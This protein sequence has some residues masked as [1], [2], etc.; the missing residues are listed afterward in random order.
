ML[1]GGEGLRLGQPKAR[2]VLAGEPLLHRVLRALHQI[3]ERL[4]VVATPGQE[5]TLP[6]GLAATVVRDL[7]AGQGPQMGLYTGLRASETEHN[8]VVGCDLPFLNLG[9]LG[10]LLSLAPGY[11]AVVP[12]PGG[13]PQQLHA[14]YAR[15]C[16]GPLESLL[17]EGNRKLGLL[18]SRVRVRSVEDEELAQYDPQGCSFFNVNTAEDLAQAHSL[19]LAPSTAERAG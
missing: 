16:L 7:V 15:S 10:Y 4:L 2:L 13:A 5:L 6:S 19:V 3:T 14:V 18:L 8:L 1:A 11:D 12:C 9:L 17:G